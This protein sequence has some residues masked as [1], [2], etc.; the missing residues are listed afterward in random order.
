VENP[1]LAGTL[2]VQNTMAANSQAIT[3]SGATLSSE[4]STQT[5]PEEDPT[6]SSYLAVPSSTQTT[7]LRGEF[8]L[9]ALLSIPEEVFSKK[10][11]EKSAS[12]SGEEFSP[13]FEKLL[14]QYRQ[15]HKI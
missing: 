6:K 12:K 8:M 13:E 14:E 5:L 15:E 9:R 4:L 11:A 2:A 3:Q 7:A 1:D 10:E